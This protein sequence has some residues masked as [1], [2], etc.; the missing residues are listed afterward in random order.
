[1]RGCDEFVHLQVA[2]SEEQTICRSSNSGKTPKKFS[3][4]CVSCT[5][6]WSVCAGVSR[7]CT[8]RS[9]RSIAPGQVWQIPGAMSGGLRG[10]A[11]QLWAW[12]LIERRW[13]HL[14]LSVELGGYPDVAIF[15]TLSG[16]PLTRSEW[17]NDDKPTFRYW[18]EPERNVF[19][20]GNESASSTQR[21]TRWMQP[22]RSS[23]TS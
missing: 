7:K 16:W 9:S 17:S 20:S 3:G 1:M 18:S 8:C 23:L 13:T 21:F 14:S 15:W 4:K 10:K 2:E 6:R 22:G 12:S 5:C 11:R 19:S